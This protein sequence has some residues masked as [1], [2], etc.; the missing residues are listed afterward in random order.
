MPD[1]IR[2]KVVQAF[3]QRLQ[4]ERSEQLSS[5]DELPARCL[6]DMD[7]SAERLA[8]GK[9]RMTLS[10]GVGVMDRVPRSVTASEKGNEMLAE[11]LEDALNQDPTLGGLTE[12]INYSDSTLD[13]PEP[14]QDIIA[15]LANFEIV[16]LTDSIS[17]YTNS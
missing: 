2:E 7:E 15:V 17:P 1:S 5:E 13:Y 10:V 3:S 12:Q 4:A 14:G 16:Y 8:Y 11:L 6:W 9:L